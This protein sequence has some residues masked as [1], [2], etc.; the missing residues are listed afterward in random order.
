MKSSWRSVVWCSLLVTGI[1]SV[2][3]LDVLPFMGTT[4]LFNYETAM[5]LISVFIYN[6]EPFSFPIGTIR[7]LTFPFQD[8]NI[9]SVGGIPLFAIFFK[10]LGKI[11][12]YFQTF[13]FFPLIELISCFA[14]AFFTQKIL[15]AHGVSRRGFLLLGALLTA[16]SFLILNRSAWTQVFCVLSFPLFTAWIYG[17][18]LTLRTN[19]WRLK[20]DICILFLF[21]IAALTDNYTLV[22]LLLATGV[23]V[24]REFFEFYFGGLES[25]KSRLMRLILFCFGG[26]ALAFTALSAIGMSSVLGGSSKF[27]SY[28]FGMG[29]R[30]HVADLLA[31]FIPVANKKTSFVHES[32]LG[33]L[34]FPFNTDNLGA[35][36]YEGVGYIG[37]AAL[38]I[39]LILLVNW[40]LKKKVKNHKVTPRGVLLL[41]SPWKK[42]AIAAGFIFIFSLGYELHI[43]GVAFPLFNGMPAAWLADR[44]PSLYNIRAPGRLVNLMMIFLIIEIVRRLALNFKKQFLLLTVLI[45][46]HLWEISPFIKPISSQPTK[47]LGGIFS[48]SEVQAIQK[49]SSGYQ[50]GLIAPSVVSSDTNWVTSA[51]SFS[52]YLKIPTNLYYLARMVP[53]HANQIDADLYKIMNGEWDELSRRYGKVL[54]AIP[55]DHVKSIRNKVQHNYQETVLGPLSIWSRRPD[56]KISKEPV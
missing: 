13:D 47:S 12:P 27:T 37:S 6:R 30:Y 45:A 38:V 5:S 51:Y 48:E 26:G 17:M 31:L 21:P 36:Q 22:G 16:T 3:F 49:I 2:R 52:Y 40:S 33:R 53:D 11:V 32:L 56:F 46:I 4:R 8:A 29:G 25:S 24:L 10:A 18:T 39:L 41:Y 7:E 28:D 50:A 14:T 54:F 19:T 55:R 35:G 1:Y 20:R 15:L 23:L 34:G 42:I 44:F 9:G 43:A